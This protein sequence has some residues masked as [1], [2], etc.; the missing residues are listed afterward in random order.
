MLTVSATY[1]HWSAAP[2]HEN[3]TILTRTL[4][5]EERLKRLNLF[6]MEKKRLRRDLIFGSKYFNKLANVDYL[7]L[8]ELRTDTRTKNKIMAFL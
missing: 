4:S 3:Y 1:P 5:Y 7:K 6:S 8:F 2:L